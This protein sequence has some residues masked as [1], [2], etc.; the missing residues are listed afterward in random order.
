M[1]ITGHA[2]AISCFIIIVLLLSGVTGYTQSSNGLVRCAPTDT[3]FTK[4][5][6]F[7][8]TLY[9]GSHIHTQPGNYTDTLSGVGGCDSIVYLSLIVNPLPVVTLAWDSMMKYG[10]FQVVNGPDTTLLINCGF[11]IGNRV[12]LHGGH[13]GGGVYSGYAVQ[14]D[15]ITTQL[16]NGTDTIFYTYTDTNGCRATASDTVEVFICGGINA[17]DLNKLFTI[18]PNPADDYAMVDFDASYTAA[19]LQVKDLTGRELLQTKLASS[20]QQLKL[21]NLPAGVYVVTLNIN[22]QV[23][24]RLLIKN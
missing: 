20:P 6:C 17:V 5:I 13:P 21:A 22:G 8:D 16:A 11:G 18:Y 14:S 23:G 15:S 3:A 24:A 19:I 10:G 1:R 2:L 7:G 12:A 4:A 9:V